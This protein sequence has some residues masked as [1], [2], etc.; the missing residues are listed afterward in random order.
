HASASATITHLNYGN[1][2]EKCYRSTLTR[3]GSNCII[4]LLATL[5]A[6]LPAIFRLYGSFDKG[7]ILTYPR[8]NLPGCFSSIVRTCP[9]FPSNS[10]TPSST[11]SIEG[12]FFRDLLLFTDTIPTMPTIAR[13]ITI[14]TLGAT[15]GPIA[16]NR[17]VSKCAFKLNC[18][19]LLFT[20]IRSVVT[21]AVELLRRPS[22]R[23][24][25]MTLSPG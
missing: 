10:R 18:P 5:K 17:A 20:I 15:N 4:R 12:H 11:S 14:A 8:L 6:F 21:Y 1:E 22:D 2:G 19:L 24:Y 25:P 13:I 23:I 9:F 7:V 16:T 3:P